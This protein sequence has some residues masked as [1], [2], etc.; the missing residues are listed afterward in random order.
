MKSTIKTNLSYALLALVAFI[1]GC[2]TLTRVENMTVEGQPSQKIAETPLRKNL[3]IKDVTMVNKAPADRFEE[4]LEGSLRAVGLFAPKD[5]GSYILTAHVQKL[6]QPFVGAN[7]TVTASIRYIV[8]ERA[9]GKEVFY[10]ILTLPYTA[11]F[12]DSFIGV[13][14]LRLATEGAIKANI[15]QLIDD[16]FS[17]NI[18]S[19][20]MN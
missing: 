15:A 1:S 13:E 4:A 3:A 6:D 18:Q 11:K 2:S 12:T 5:V 19:V 14:R 16:L 9:T 10:K 17:L 20:S 7:M 8:T